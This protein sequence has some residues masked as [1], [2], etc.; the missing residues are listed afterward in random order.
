VAE[1]AIRIAEALQHPASLIAA[2]GS[3][4]PW[5]L[6]GEF[7]PAIRRLERALSLCA[8]PDT[9]LEY[10]LVAKWLGY[11]YTMTGRLADAL[12][13]LEAAVERARRVNRRMEASVTINLG[14]AYLA[15]GRT[16]DALAT[17]ERVLALARERSER[18]NEAE[19]L[20]LLGEVASRLDPADPDEAE[21]RYGEAAALSDELAARP[22]LAH[23]HLGLGRLHRRNGRG[24]QARKHLGIATIMYREMEMRLWLEHAGAEQQEL[25]R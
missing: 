22:L 25:T 3:C 19:A 17:A 2:Y 9:Y 16:D 1:E 13:L 21:T 23:C 7:E 20:H 15:A 24:E 5:L 18:G 6:R 11:A 12:A 8:T 4:S 10:V 14:Q